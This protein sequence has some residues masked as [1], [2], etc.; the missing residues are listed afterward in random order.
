MGLA[1]FALLS[2]LILWLL[3][4]AVQPK[5]TK[6]NTHALRP[7][8]HR[9]LATPTERARLS[10]VVW[11]A[12]AKATSIKR[13]KKLAKITAKRRK[14]RAEQRNERLVSTR[15]RRPAWRPCAH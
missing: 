12:T 13:K 8:G 10:T 11:R 2:A 3:S 1:I 5:Q 14:A 9:V 6:K 4:I 7:K 15:N